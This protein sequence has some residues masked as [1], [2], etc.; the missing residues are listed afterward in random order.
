MKP[1]IDDQLH[2]S[3]YLIAAARRSSQSLSGP[4]RRIIARRRDSALAAGYLDRTIRALEMEG[5]L[6]QRRAMHYP[7]QARY[8]GSQEVGLFGIS[9]RFYNI[10]GDHVLN[11]STVG[12]TTLIHSGI[13]PP[14]LSFWG[15]MR[16]YAKENFIIVW[17][18]ALST[19]QVTKIRL[20]QPWK[21]RA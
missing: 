19:W 1:S 4:D 10:E 14:D 15:M 3:G 17:W 7:I 5:E 13:F 9:A 8:I 20:G 12:V 2:N 21:K 16:E 11:N 6:G 18:F